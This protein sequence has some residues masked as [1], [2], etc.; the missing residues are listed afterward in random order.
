MNLNGYTCQKCG[1]PRGHANHSEC[2]RIMQAESKAK[3][4]APK[5]PRKGS[6]AFIVGLSRIE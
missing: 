4:R 6:E 3:S 5:K 1:K 2:S